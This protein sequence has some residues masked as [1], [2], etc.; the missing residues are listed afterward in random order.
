MAL[1]GYKFAGYR[2]TKPEN[3]T[4][5]EW[6]L[7]IHKTRLKA[8]MAANTLAGDIWEFDRNSGDVA[9][10][11]YGNV[12]YYADRTDP[13][14]L[15]SFFKHSTEDK[16][17]AIVSAFNYYLATGTYSGLVRFSWSAGVSAYYITSSNYHKLYQKQLFHVVSYDRFDENFLLYSAN[18]YPA[19][20]LGL[21]PITNFQTNSAGSSTVT[22]NTANEYG[23]QSTLRFGCALRD[24]DILTISI[25]GTDLSNHDLFK[26]SLVGFDSMAL[27]SP[28]DT[29]NIYGIVLG[30]D[31]YS[32]GPNN[33]GSALTNFSYVQNTLKDNFARYEESGLYSALTL[34][35]SGKALFAG[36]PQLIPFESVT[37]KTMGDRLQ[38]PF[39]NSDGIASK[40]TFNISLLS[41]NSAA[42]YT[43]TSTMQTYA[44]GNYLLALRRKA[45]GTYQTNYYVGWDPSNPDIT[46]EDAWAAYDGT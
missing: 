19:R 41:E 7:L 2:C 21:V 5:A 3:A 28:N 6:A 46:S 40:G 25:N 32:I 8:F 16:Y 11:T 29:A 10:E 37:L 13:L 9:F 38:S 33:W 27:S 18:N 39:M 24:K 43:S 30:T 4:D 22:I 12:I 36:T 44:N 15:V 20:S 23:S 34:T 42:Q 17:Y 45:N 14:N 1:G 35:W 26:V 31:T